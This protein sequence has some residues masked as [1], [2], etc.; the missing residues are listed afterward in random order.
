MPIR[1]HGIGDQYF[2]RF[3]CNR[4]PDPD[5]GGLLRKRTQP[6]GRLPGTATLMSML[7]VES[8]EECWDRFYRKT[9]CCVKERYLQL[10]HQE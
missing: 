7:E 2:E 6:T 9:E 3:E 8:P 4:E 10:Q 5:R 1:P